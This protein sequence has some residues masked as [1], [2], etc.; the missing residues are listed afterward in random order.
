MTTVQR[1][2]TPDGRPRRR[3]RFTW[4][5]RFGG[6]SDWSSSQLASTGAHVVGALVFLVA[7]HRASGGFDAIWWGLAAVPLLTMSFAG[8]GAP[9]GF[10]GLMVYGWFYLSPAGSFSW[11]SVPAA[12]GL[13][14]GHASAAVSASTPPQAHIA[15]VELARWARWTGI[16]V[17]AALPIG[18]FAAVVVGR[19]TSLVPVAAVVGLLG[20]AGTL[21]LLRTRP[22]ETFT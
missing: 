15:R 18:A 13:A 8:S 5:V 1:P 14:I 11:W 9:L 12:A 19:S 2:A 16:A 22:P 21:L 6:G 10:W 17:A 7:L 3:R 4:T 20:V